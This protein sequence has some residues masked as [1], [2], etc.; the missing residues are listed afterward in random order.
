MNVTHNVCK[1]TKMSQKIENGKKRRKRLGDCFDLEKPGICQFLVSL[2]N[3]SLY[4]RLSRVQKDVISGLFV[5]SQIFGHFCPFIK[6]C[7]LL[8]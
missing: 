4:F 6:S 2:D 1:S 8:L 3:F 7:S 5:L